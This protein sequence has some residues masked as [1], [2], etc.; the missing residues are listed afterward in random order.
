MLPHREEK[1]VYLWEELVLLGDLVEH[2]MSLNRWFQVSS[3]NLGEKRQSLLCSSEP[4]VG[5]KPGGLFPDLQTREEGQQRVHPAAHAHGGIV[6][7][8]VEQQRR[9]ADVLHDGAVV[10]SHTHTCWSGHSQAERM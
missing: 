6:H 1:G 5:W 3:Q 7:V 2:F 9:L 4:S 8:D 10:L